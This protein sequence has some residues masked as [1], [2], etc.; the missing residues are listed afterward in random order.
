MRYTG[1]GYG[2]LLPHCDPVEFNGI[3]WHSMVSDVKT[4]ISGV[5]IMIPDVRSMISVARIMVSDAI[6]WFRVWKS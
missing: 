1:K 4:M 6:S 5:K 2:L 3:Q